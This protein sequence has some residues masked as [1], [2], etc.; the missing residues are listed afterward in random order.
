MGVRA[1]RTRGRLK[2]PAKGDPGR[3]RTPQATRG[4]PSKDI[5]AVLRAIARTAARLCDASNAHIYRLE[6]DQLRLEAIQESEPMRRVGEAIPVTPVLPTGHAVLA[7]RTIH[8]RDTKTAAAQR[9]YPGLKPP[10]PRGGRLDPPAESLARGLDAPR[11]REP[12]RWR[13]GSLVRSTGLMWSFDGR[14][15][16]R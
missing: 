2:S 14:T 4:G 15:L 10:H 12:F 7:R 8:R 11:P 13:N 9:R 1:A 3:P 5:P 6:G 16:M